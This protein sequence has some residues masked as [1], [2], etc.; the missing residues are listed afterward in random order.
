LLRKAVGRRQKALRAE[1]LIWASQA[2][3]FC[4]HLSMGVCPGSAAGIRV[5]FGK[6]QINPNDAFR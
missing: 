2:Q 1:P 4:E 3:R 5:L 6:G